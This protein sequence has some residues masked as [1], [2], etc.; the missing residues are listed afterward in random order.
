MA[1]AYTYTYSHEQIG[2][3]MINSVAS[4]MYSGIS[5]AKNVWKRI[6]STGEDILKFNQLTISV[7]AVAT[8]HTNKS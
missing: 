1:L 2:L 6:R 4:Y 7:N 3:L 8:T 5:I